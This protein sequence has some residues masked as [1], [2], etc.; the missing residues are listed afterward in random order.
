MCARQTGYS[1]PILYK[2]FAI[3]DEVARNQADCGVSDLARRLNISKSTVYGITQAFID[4]GVLTQGADSKKFRLGPT[5]V[6][7]GNQALAGMDLRSIA[8]PFME[9][10]SREFKVTVFLGTFDE[11][12]ITIIEKVDS[13]QDLKISAPVGTRIPIFAGAAAKVFLA[14]LK[15]KALNKILREKSIPKY[16]ENTVT[17]PGEYRAELARVRDQG[18]ATD[19][20]EYIRGVNAV[21]VPVL[22]SWGWPVAAIWMVGFSNFFNRQQ[23]EKACPAAAGVA[24]K[25]GAMLKGGPAKTSAPESSGR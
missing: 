12:G 14:G 6:Q 2:A 18:F 19:Y 4:L 16:T 11:F 1:A 21:S 22:D 13:P 23:M 10:L 24:V 3:L 15:D 8:L 20:E 7:L 5:L 17:D 25:I 9:E